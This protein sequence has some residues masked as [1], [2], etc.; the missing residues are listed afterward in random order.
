M[1]G[2]RDA[3]LASIRGTGG[4]GAL[5][6]TDKSQLE[7]PSVLLQEARGESPAA[8]QIS[9]AP[10]APGQPESLADALA[11]ALNKRKDKVAASDDEDDED[12]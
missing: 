3:L 10:A 9:A 4:I 12:W 11:N 1:D 8:S 6:K 7:K 2:G 5:K